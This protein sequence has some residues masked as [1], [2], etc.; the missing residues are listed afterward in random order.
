MPHILEM[1]DRKENTK[2]QRKR[3]SSYFS[4]IETDEYLQM[5][6]PSQ[7]TSLNTIRGVK[8]DTSRSIF[9]TYKF[10]LEQNIN[11]KVYTFAVY[12]NDT[13][14]VLHAVLFSSEMMSFPLFIVDMN[15]QYTNGLIQTDDLVITK[16]KP[17]YV[18]ELGFPLFSATPRMVFDKK[19][20]WKGLIE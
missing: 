5:C 2:S 17:H 16:H 18:I 15:E 6:D 13:E 19:G 9:L 4:W 1:M 7:V 3:S 8:E 20:L 11:G 12:D 10:F 14:N